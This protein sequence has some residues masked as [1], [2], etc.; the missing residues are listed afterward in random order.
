[1]CF[2]QENYPEEQFI[3]AGDHFQQPGS[4]QQVLQDCVEEST[5]LTI[6]EYWA[7]KKRE[8]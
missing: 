2:Q 1:M 8:S 3:D 4:E 7:L 6:R 5:A